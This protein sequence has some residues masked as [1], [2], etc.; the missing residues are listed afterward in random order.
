MKA[1]RKRVLAKRAAA[2]SKG[3]SVDEDD[4]PSHGDDA[5]TPQ[6][7]TA[8]STPPVVAVAAAAPAVP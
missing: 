8:R 2:L 4:D 1:L 3:E 7:T 5:R 6:I